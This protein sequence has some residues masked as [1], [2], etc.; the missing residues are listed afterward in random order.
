MV[1][2]GSG[3]GLDCFFAGQRVGPTGHVIGVDMTP[4]MLAKA[5]ANAER[6]GAT[7]VE[8]REG[9]IE[10]LPVADGTRGRRHFELCYQLVPEQTAGLGRH[11]SRAALWGR[12]AVSDIVT[13]GELPEAIRGQH[14][15]VGRLRGRALW[16]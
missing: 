15:G 9:Y 3:G 11:F 2:L 16:T 5:R 12:V 1:D 6:V 14:G 8:F 7:N 10:H 4:E 13:D